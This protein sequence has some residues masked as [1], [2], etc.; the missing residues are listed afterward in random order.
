M[1]NFDPTES[2]IDDIRNGRM[3]VLLDDEDREN[4][5]DL[6]M[7]AEYVTADSINFMATHARGL[8][9]LTL[10]GQRCEQL[11]LSPMVTNNG[12]SFATAFTVSIE[13]REGV[14][15]G[16][17]AADR[18]TTV[19]A[20]VA[21]DAHTRD[22][23]QPGHIFPLR[24]RDGGVLSRAGHTEAGCDLTRL[25]GLEPAAVI[26]EIMNDDGSMARRPE[27]EAFARRHGIR[28][29]TIAD[30]IQYRLAREKTVEHTGQQPL[31]TA[32]GDFVLHTYEDLITGDA[33]L[34]LTM[35]DLSGSEPTLVRVHSVDP[36][37]D[38]VGADYRGPRAWSLW[39][40]LENV[41][42]AG[43]GAVVIL[44]SHESSQSLL[45]RATRQNTPPPD[46]SSIRYSSVGTGSQILSDLGIRKLRLMGAPLNYKGLSGFDL[47]VVEIVE[48]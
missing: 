28:I 25:A 37:R 17:S 45:S 16:I 13:A 4:E 32:H 44:A 34:A 46:A 12:A 14:T 48:P 24:A 9:C 30:L 26:V 41:A 1:M 6:V 29:G 47:E 27:L 33:H 39:S 18:A 23:V 20:A 8:I 2:L 15:T 35:G 21:P 22:L 31:S 38:L 40:A 3:V 43:H 11:G 10:S 36:L 7:A 5:G 42:R 19:K